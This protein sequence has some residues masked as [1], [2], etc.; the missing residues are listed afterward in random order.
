MIIT[1]SQHGPYVLIPVSSIIIN[2]NKFSLV[3]VN[4]SGHSKCADMGQTYTVIIITSLRL[5]SEQHELSTCECDK[6]IRAY[7]LRSPSET[8]GTNSPST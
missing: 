2:A 4:A 7:N 1:T 6:R 5:D 8:D 3:Q